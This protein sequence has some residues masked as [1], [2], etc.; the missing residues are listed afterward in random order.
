MN[1]SI[2]TAAKTMAAVIAAGAMAV[3]PVAG[4]INFGAMTAMAGQTTAGKPAQTD[5]GTIT[6]KNIENG[7]TVK[8]YQIISANWKSNGDFNAWTVDSK[9][10]TFVSKNSDDTYKVNV[11]NLSADINT[12]SKGWSVATA[13][14][15]T[16]QLTATSNGEATGVVFNNVKPGT[17]LALVTPPEAKKVETYIY[18]PMLISVDY[19]DNNLHNGSV[20]A[21]TDSDSNLATVTYAKRKPVSLTKKITNPDTKWGEETNSSTVADGDDLQVGDTQN[22][23]LTTA[24]P[25]YR[26]YSSSADIKFEISDNQDAGFNKPTTDPVVKVGGTAYAATVDGTVNFTIKYGTFANEPIN[27]AGY[28]EFTESTTGND[29]KIS[30]TRAFLDA[31]PGASVTVEYSSVLNKDAT[32]KLSANDNDVTLTYT[33]DY[34]GDTKVKDDHTYDYSFPVDVKKVD[35]DGTTVPTSNVESER[36]QFKIERMM[37]STSGSLVAD[38]ASGHVAY[39]TDTNEPAILTVNEQ[40]ML[41]FNH[42]DEGYYKITEERAP[43]GY[44]K[45]TEAFYIKITPLNSDKTEGYNSDG[46]I[47]D[48]KVERVNENGEVFAD[49]TTTTATFTAHTTTNGANDLLTVKDTKVTGLPSTGARSALILTIAG[50]AVMITVMAASRRKKIAD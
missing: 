9:A 6:I 49:G 34:T 41:T 36:A 26:G 31:H 7:A 12:T 32:Q 37:K 38:S 5:T 44:T 45:N 35:T 1:N 14:D 11:Q 18:N 22:F 21:N 13:S 8:L 30:F 33:N 16:T 23:T 19:Q 40:G 42:L 47:S 4:T 39:G 20:D 25:D 3:A 50:I 24:F 15:G 10:E 46:T 43:K 48:W 28:G 29:F 2:R 27:D 17:Y